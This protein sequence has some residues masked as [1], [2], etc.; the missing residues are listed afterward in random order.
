MPLGNV[1]IIDY[2]IQFLLIN[3]IKNIIIFGTSHKEQLDEYFKKYKS[4]EFSLKIVSSDDCLW[5]F[6]KSKKLV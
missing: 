4:K 1:M 2:V 6:F 3:K 5:Y